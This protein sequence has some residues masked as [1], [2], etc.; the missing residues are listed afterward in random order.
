MDYI[1]LVLS[2]VVMGLIAAVPIGPVNLICIRRT[3]AYGPVNGF[4]SGLGAAMGDGVFAAVTGFGLTWV[5]QL[6][7]GYSVIIELIGGTMLLYFGVHAFISPMSTRVEETTKDQGA[8]TLA[9]AM[10]STFALTVT[11]PATLFAF[12][13]MFAS[14][15]GIAGGQTSFMAAGFVVAGVVGGSTAWWL[16]LT[17][18]IGLFHARIDD[19]IVRIINRCSGVAVSLFGVVVLIHVLHKLW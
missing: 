5:S 8:S 3:F 6:I 15:G 1:L 11:N 13:A 18:L 4:V 17:T 2:G 7:V 14:F 19:R 9:R 10:A 16:A 12:T